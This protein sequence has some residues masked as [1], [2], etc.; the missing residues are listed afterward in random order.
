MFEFCFLLSIA[1]CQCVCVCTC[2]DPDIFVLM[3]ACMNGSM[4]KEHNLQPTA[5]TSVV[6][7]LQ[8]PCLSNAKE[9]TQYTS[10]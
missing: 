8:L 1:Q 10:G 5:T 6:L 9:K 2:D 7:W 4:I 3:H